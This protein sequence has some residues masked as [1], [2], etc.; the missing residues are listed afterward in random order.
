MKMVYLFYYVLNV[1]VL[2]NLY[3]ISD[4]QMVEVLRN[5]LSE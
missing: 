4:D 2:K 1:N 5:V 3:P